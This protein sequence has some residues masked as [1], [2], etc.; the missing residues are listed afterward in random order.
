MVKS[1]TKNALTDVD[2]ELVIHA[3]IEWKTYTEYVTASD[4]NTDE[5][6]RRRPGHVRRSTQV[7]VEQDAPKRKLVQQRLVEQEPIVEEYM[8]EETREEVRHKPRKY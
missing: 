4:S 5:E 2:E 3:D 6:T 8:S 1:G 7:I